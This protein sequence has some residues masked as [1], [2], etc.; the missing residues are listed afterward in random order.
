MEGFDWPKLMRAGFRGL[1]LRPDEFWALTPVEL[2]LMLGE[3]SGQIPMGRARLDELLAAYP[4]E[5]KGD[6]S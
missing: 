6:G 5:V 3:E 2:R 1:G 4:D